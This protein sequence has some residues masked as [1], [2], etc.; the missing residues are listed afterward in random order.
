M[1]RAETTHRPNASWRLVGAAALVACAA[2]LSVCVAKIFDGASFGAAF[3]FAGALAILV[4]VTLADLVSGV[5]HY[6]A[7]RFGHERI[8]VLGTNLIAPFRA[9]HDD[10]REMVR[11]D[12]VE[13]NGDSAVIEVLPLAAF[14]LLMPATQGSVLCFA[15][16]VAGTSFF[17]AVLATNQIHKWAHA[18]D[19]PRAVRWLQRRGAILSPAEH[20]RH[21]RA[22]DRAYSITTG[23][24]NAALDRLGLLDALG[25][26]MQTVLPRSWIVDSPD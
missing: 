24:C 14:A 19:V 7:D 18:E 2:G 8:P 4:G 6:L 9:H 10:P 12:F 5:V 17:V 11:H 15:L 22:H 26:V 25:R 21:H 3:V 1:D 20:A 16:L 13:T 23:W